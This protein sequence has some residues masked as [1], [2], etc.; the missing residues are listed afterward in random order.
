MILKRTEKMKALRRGRLLKG[1]FFI[2][3]SA[4]TRNDLIRKL[5]LFGYFGKD[6]IYQPHLLPMDPKMIKL[7]DN[8]KVSNNVSFITHDA[9]QEVYKCM[10]ENQGKK[11]R[12]S[13]GCIEVMQDC[14]IG[15]GSIIM[16]GVRIGPRAVVA[17][18]S[19][20]TKDVPEGAI[21]GGN[22]AKVIGSFDD[23][24]R[25][26]EEMSKDIE[27]DNRFSKERIDLAWKKFYEDHP[28]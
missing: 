17:A 21:V 24:M 20:V 19:V 16:P 28:D 23:L 22:P 9:M 4:K 14:F 6:V 11:F 25:R 12:Q 27:N 1:L 13:V 15:L 7:H 10:E 8:V 2:I 18:G 5:D 26:Q 3:P